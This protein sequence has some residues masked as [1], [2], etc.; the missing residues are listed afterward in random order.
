MSLDLKVTGA[1][2]WNCRC[3]F[4]MA[5]F[6]TW[7]TLECLIQIE[8]QHRGMKIMWAKILPSIV[9]TRLFGMPFLFF[10][11][12]T[13][14]NI[15]GSENN[16]EWTSFLSK[17]G[18]KRI[19]FLAFFFNFPNHNLYPPLLTYIEYSLRGHEVTHE[20]WFSS[21][22]IWD[23]VPLWRVA[24]MWSPGGSSR[25]HPRVGDHWSLGVDGILAQVERVK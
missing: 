9:E 15:I 4:V 11:D 7:A 13:K 17:R 3:W 1:D 5:V 10:T 21:W 6:L 12:F 18:K 24:E 16:T 19:Y 2:T 25:G 23:I 20:I 22:N 8:E 14:Y